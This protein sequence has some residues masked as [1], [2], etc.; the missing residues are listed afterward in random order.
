MVNNHLLVSCFFGLPKIS[1]SDAPDGARAVFFTNSDINAATAASAG[2]E[3][4]L[5]NDG[6][7]ALSSDLRVSSVQAK[8]VK[9]LQF[10]YDFDDLAKYSVIT[11][12]DHNG[13]MQDKQLLELAAR[14]DPEK[15]I[16][17]RS[18]SYKK[19]LPKEIELSKRQPRYNASMDETL[20]WLENLRKKY[21]ISD[22][23][24]IAAT[25]MIHITRVD[26]MMP[27]FDAVYQAIVDLNQPQCQI[28]WNIL[29]QK[30]ADDIHQ[31]GWR[32][33]QIPWGEP[34]VNRHL[35]VY[36]EK[37]QLAKE[38]MQLTK[39]KDQLIKEKTQLIKENDRLI[40]EKTQL[41]NQLKT[42][43]IKR[44]QLS[45]RNSELLNSTSWR[46]TKPLRKIGRLI[47][48]I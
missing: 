14:M 47:R 35:P 16:L 2:W 42:V 45:M 27:L 48:N 37:D 12:C 30:Y 38:K 15:S 36:D 11:Y 6:G 44:D 3:P 21:E 1:I 41:Q 13:C 46:F 34:A 24:Q 43:R 22:S 4:I 5:M 28:I 19:G 29:S 33:L 10:R 8:Y 9:F 26:K 32:D 25:G 40:K 18:S 20:R 31:V 39:E 23:K 7:F 17:I